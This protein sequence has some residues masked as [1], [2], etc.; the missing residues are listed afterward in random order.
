MP[1]PIVEHQYYLGV[2]GQQYGPFGAMQVV[3]MTQSGQ[4]A[5]AGTKVWRAGLAAWGELGQLPELAIML[6]A[7]AAPMMPPPLV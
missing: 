7:P 6:Q 5:V 4:V 2:A 3:Q 1:P